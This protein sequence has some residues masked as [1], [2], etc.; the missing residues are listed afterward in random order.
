MALMMD[1]AGDG[2]MA[3]PG[4]ESGLEYG[5]VQ[6]EQVGG[7]PVDGES[8]AQYVIK[9][10]EER[11]V[12]F[13]QL[14]FTDVLGTLK[15]F[16]IAPAEVEGAL[17]DGM[18]FD[19]S[20]VDGFSRV[21]E[22]DM[23]AH[24]DPGTFELLPWNDGDT[25]TARMFCD[26][27]NPDGTPFDGSPREVLR[28]AIRRAQAA[29]YGFFAGPEIEFFYFIEDGSGHR[30][31]PIDN[32]SYF[33]LTAA[34]MCGDLR[35]GSIQALEEMGIPVEHTQHE[36]APGQY[37]IDLRYTDALTMADTVMTT[38]MIVKEVALRHGVLASFMPKPLSGVQG[39]GMH[40]H[41]SLFKG[42]S[43]A[44][45]DPDDPAGLSQVAKCF[46]AGLL[47]HAPEI[48]AVTNQWVNSYK[49]LVPG[50][51]APAHV[52][53]ARNNRSALVRVPVVRRSK[54]DT[55][56][57]EYRAIDSACNPYLSFALIL[58]AGMKGLEEGYELPPE[59]AVNLFDLSSREL[60]AMGVVQLPHNLFEAVSLM[61]RSQLVADTVGAHVFEWF[62]RN[63]LEEWHAFR[64][65][66]SEFEL[67]RY[68]KIL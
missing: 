12:Q 8:G 52:S 3:D 44:F 60:D 20:A 1:A 63:K 37:E 6:A 26:I 2:M 35:R 42:E 34:E 53:W 66:V 13:V 21:Q 51:E 31:Q 64:E 18:T 24:P 50:Y 57:I 62:T 45:Y 32:G 15:A 46:V 22:S 27:A 5:K 33:D 58:A 19:G 4:D 40:T 61:E 17:E 55:T 39:S 59:T 29:G 38:R 43:N 47:R 36:D 10:V 68:L 28:R 56:R 14:W 16:S 7:F 65:H 9:T 54:P 30:P 41:L 49:R 23:V 48:T 25:I 11:G 67:D